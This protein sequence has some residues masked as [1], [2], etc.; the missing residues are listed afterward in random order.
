[1]SEL[2]NQCNTHITDIKIGP[3]LEEYYIG[4]HFV[5]SFSVRNLPIDKPIQLFIGDKFIYEFTN[6]KGMDCNNDVDYDY[7]LIYQIP[8]Y[9]NSGEHEIKLIYGMGNDI[10]RKNINIT[11]LNDYCGDNLN[12]CKLICDIDGDEK[13]DE[14]DDLI[15]VGENLNF[16]LKLFIHSH[17][18]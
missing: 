4:Q 6:H 13:I 12:Y 10:I 5:I 17:Q 11:T 14:I 18:L 8:E 2:F 1:M 16:I 15:V 3:H 9:L 7:Q